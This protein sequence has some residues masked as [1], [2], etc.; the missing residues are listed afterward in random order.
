MYFG[1]RAPK[2]SVAVIS[3]LAL[4]LALW[5]IAPAVVGVLRIVGQKYQGVMNWVAFANPLV[6]AVTAMGGLAGEGT[7]DRAWR[8]I[9]FSQMDG[10][11]DQAWTFATMLATYA[12]VYISAGLGFLALAKRRMRKKVF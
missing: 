6:Q 5:L 10:D 9:R 11:K 12:G 3:N 4:V 2:T 7:A 8:Q 1:T